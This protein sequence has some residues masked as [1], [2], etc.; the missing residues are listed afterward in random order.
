MKLRPE[1]TLESLCALGK[2][3]LP[4]M[5]DLRPIS[6]AQGEFAM[7]MEVQPQFLAPNGYLHA[8]SVI[9]LADSSCGYACVAHLPEGAAGFTT[10]ELKTNFLATA[11][12]GAI[13][14]VAKAV[15]FGRNTQVWDAMVSSL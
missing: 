13:E 10:I 11:R 1:I 2:D 5:F 3:H 15:H 6:L 12:S 4:G 7:R 14:S 9:A 8:A